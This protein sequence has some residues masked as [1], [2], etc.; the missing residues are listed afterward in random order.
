MTNGVLA[1]SLTT[2]DLHK[3][4][5]AEKDFDTSCKKLL[6]FKEILARIMKE[7][8]QEY[9]HCSIRD[10]IERYIEGE[11]QISETE[12]S[13]D[14]TNRKETITGLPNE[15]TTVSEGKVYFDIL[16]SAK[17]PSPAETIG[18]FIN[19]EAQHYSNTGYN[20]LKRA[21]YYC[22]RMI[23]SQKT[24]VFNHSDYND[25]QKVYSIFIC[26]N[27]PLYKQNSINRYSMQ[28]EHLHGHH[29]EQRSAYDLT[30]IIML[31]LGKGNTRHYSGIVKMLDVLLS[32]NYEAK[33][34]KEILE[35]EFHIPM[36]HDI[37]MEVSNMCNLS[38]GVLERGRDAL[39]AELVRK[40]L[41]KGKTPEAIAEDLEESVATIQ[42]IVD[43]LQPHNC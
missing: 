42:K 30:S 7:C 3:R 32:S 27:P 28:E 4:T 5:D 2:Y 33:E 15:D 40:K 22:S 20:L 26:D 35:N 31:N 16:Y 11:P 43:S 6:A 13:H 34:K 21:T 19:I 29:C 1:T 41:T 9:E 10:I 8:L 18:L 24:K 36:S 25:I 38:Q 14:R 12:V 37:N 23:S 39:L 17:V